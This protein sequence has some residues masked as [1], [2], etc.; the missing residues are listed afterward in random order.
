MKTKIYLFFL[1][2]PVI[3]ILFS[4]KTICQC[5]ITVTASINNASCN[6]T[7]D[8]EITLNVTGSSNL[9]YE[10]AGSSNTTATASG[11][12]AGTYNYTVTDNSGSSSTP[13]PSSYPILRLGMSD[14]SNTLNT[15]VYFHSMATNGYDFAMDG[16]YLAGFTS[17]QFA[18]LAGTYQLAINGLPP[19]STST[20][21]IP[22]FTNTSV[23]GNYSIEQTEFSNFPAG[24]QLILEDLLLSTTHD[25]TSGAYNYTG[26]P[27]DGTSRFNISIIPN[28]TT[29]SAGCSVSGTVTITEP[30]AI[31]VSANVTPASCNGTTDGE[32]SLSVTGGNNHI[33][34][35]TGSSSSSATA[36]GLSAG[37]YNYTVTSDGGAG[38]SEPGSVTVTEPAAI[39]IGETITNASC[40]GSSDGEINL[41]VGSSINLIYAWSGSSSSTAAATGLSAGTYNYTV[42]ENNGSSASTPSSYPVLRLEMSDGNNSINS[43]IFFWA[44]ATSGFDVFYDALYLPG[45]TSFQFATMAGTYQLTNN[46]LPPL[47]SSTVT[48]PLYT[49]ITIAGNY[50]IE[51]TEFSN[52]PAGTQL[53]L[54]DLLLSTTH[55]LTSGAYN[56]TGNPSDGTSRFNISIIPDSSSS[57]IGCSVSGTVTITEPGPLAP[58]T[59]PFTEDFSGISGNG[60]IIGNGVIY[61][62][63]SY[64]WT[65]QTTDKSN[66]TASWGTNFPITGTTG[67][68]L[69]TAT[70]SAIGNVTNEA[71]LTLDLSNYSSNADLE[72]SFD[73]YDNTDD[74]NPNDRVWI[75]G[76]NSDSWIEAF[77]LTDGPNNDWTSSEIID[78]DALLSNAT[79]VQTLSSTFQIKFGQEDNSSWASGDGIGFDNIHIHEYNCIPI[80][81]PIYAPINA[82]THANKTCIKIEAGVEW[83]YYYN[84]SSSEELLFAIAHDPNNLGN[85]AFTADVSINVST[86][87]SNDTNFVNGIYK[88]EDIPNQT[89][90]I[91]LGRYWN[92]T[93]NGL[94]VDP[95]N[96]RFYF[97]NSEKD[98]ITSAAYTWQA[99]HDAAPY[100]IGVGNIEW[101]K[102]TNTQY[103]PSTVL[104][105]SA[106][107]GT[108]DYTSSSTLGTT[109]S[110]INYVQ[111]DNIT[112]FSG[113]SGAINISQSQTLDVTLT[114]FTVHK[115]QSNKSKLYWATERE[116]DMSHYEIQRSS[117]GLAYETIG[118]VQPK[119]GIG[120]SANYEFIDFYPSIGFNYYRLKMVEITGH[121]DYSN[122]KVLEF[123]GSYNDINIMP[124]PI[125][126]ELNIVVNSNFEE[127]VSVTIFNT[128][129]QTFCHKSFTV[130]KGS[131]RLLLTFDQNLAEGNYILCYK[132]SNNNIYKKIVKQ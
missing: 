85:N 74:M 115:F 9:T 61:C 62:G 33:Y 51:Q 87:P 127:T 66:G 80:A 71:I 99:N 75:R 94:L 93:T 46:A 114:N 98:A 47:G 59:L 7:N 102:T 119:G 100:Q 37:T 24:T 68:A 121:I 4:T 16:L 78:I 65:F 101:F 29:S 124:N 42:T 110:G 21:I 18:T 122:I 11:L 72:L 67:L 31:S 54:E 91:A 6:G 108:Q 79:P 69:S 92:A 120:I 3:L 8:G 82:I 113:G 109:A 97:Q 56:Y 15:L 128:L 96:I 111:I 1:L 44:Q 132:N 17:F 20:V 77:D 39:S 105:P 55:D 5:P 23:A 53:I 129:G 10:W 89:C 36:T 131:N 103:D 45:L 32:I 40:N 2:I 95:V 112:S 22:L 35:W 106:L 19:I 126:K 76:S 81:Q 12:S 41:S 38:C 58:A 123:K 43:V 130:Q 25:L 50:S 52:F 117:D 118:V 64:S 49:D 30:S 125:D 84:I 107:V 27:S 104:T 14:A 60:N 63:P 26:N 86:E 88:A 90:Y 34:S 48:V 70:N 83:T 116:E 13:P 28:S 73:Y 57:S